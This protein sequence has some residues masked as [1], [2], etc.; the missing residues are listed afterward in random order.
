M[1]TAPTP[2]PTVVWPVKCPSCGSLYNGETHELVTDTKLREKISG[3]ETELATLRSA[4][5]SLT[6]DLAAANEKITA[7]SAPPPPADDPPPAA[8]KKGRDFIVGER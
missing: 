2:V 1:A 6:S 8:R 3:L 7:L 4:N 5:Q